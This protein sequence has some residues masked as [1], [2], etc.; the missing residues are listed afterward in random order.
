MDRLRDRVIVV[1]G[2]AQGIGR[3]YCEAVAR[4]G[5]RVVVA[6]I[7][8]SSAERLAGGLQAAGTPALGLAVDVADPDA[9]RHMASATVERFGRIDGLV[10]NAAMFQ[11][12]AVSRAPFDELSLEEWDR[13]MAVNVRG[14]FLC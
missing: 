8:A 13:V 1:T 4:E 3:A 2:G 10:N 9:T 7:A 12:P 5:A 14:V 11:R 6:D